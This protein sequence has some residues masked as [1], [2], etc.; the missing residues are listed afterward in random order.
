VRVRVAV[1]PT[2]PLILLAVLCMEFVTDVLSLST[3][4]D[5]VE[6]AI[7][8]KL[9]GK[10]L[11]LESATTLAPGELKRKKKKPSQKVRAQ[12]RAVRRR[13]LLEAAAVVTYEQLQRQHIVWED[14]VRSS[15]GAIFGA[16]M[17]AKAL[18]L[19][20]HG[21]HLR[22][23]SSLSPSHTGAQG[24]LLAETRRMLLLLSATR[25]LWVPKAGT[26][27]ELALPNGYL[28]QCEAVRHMEPPHE[29]QQAQNRDQVAAAA[30]A[31][32]RPSTSKRKRGQGG[33]A[34]HA[35]R[36]QSAVKLP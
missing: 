26:I 25:R 15:L 17:N 16:D 9:R 10:K 11:L 14:Y 12:P 1:G 20:W 30:K 28:A 2:S 19:D 24:L 3:R 6:A 36:V 31:A 22:V 32:K 29:Q 13:Q 23:V 7:K 18:Q 5:R 33:S 34:P 8:A 35:S 21:A 4:R 27:V